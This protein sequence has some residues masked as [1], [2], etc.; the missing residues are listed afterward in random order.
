MVSDMIVCIDSTLYTGPKPPC[1]SLLDKW[2]L[3]VAV[4]SFSKSNSNSSCKL[5]CDSPPSPN[6]LSL[7]FCS[8]VPVP[9]LLNCEKALLIFFHVDLSGVQNIIPS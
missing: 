7:V 3:F 2:K 4:A 6:T 1:P 9:L 5:T 8:G